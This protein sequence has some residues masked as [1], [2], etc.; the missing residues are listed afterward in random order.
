MPPMIGVRVLLVSGDIQTIDTLCDFME[1]MA[2][3]VDVC[4]DF[5][6]ATRKL[7]H[8][9]FEAVAVDFK[10]SA[11]ALDLLKKLRHMTSHKSAVVLAILDDNDQM[12]SAFRGGAS[13]VVVRPLS[14]AAL[15]RTLRVS[16]P[17]CCMK[18][19]AT[20]VV[21]CRSQSISPWVS[22]LSRGLLPSISARVV[23]LSP[24]HLPYRLEKEWLCG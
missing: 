8:S 20:F 10:E 5:A 9:K 11:E 16:Y 7:C 22:G 23:W 21:L 14:Q 18:K 15:L 2:M 1:K 3:H 19:G 6:S 13:F 24:T 17:L 12:P 4:S